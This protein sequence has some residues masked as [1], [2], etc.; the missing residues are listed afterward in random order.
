MLKTNLR[1][2]EMVRTEEQDSLESLE[3]LGSWWLPPSAVS[4]SQPQIWRFSRR[5]LVK[6]AWTQKK[7]TLRSDKQNITRSTCDIQFRTP[8]KP[9]ELSRCR[10]F[11]AILTSLISFLLSLPC[12]S[13]PKIH[14]L[15]YKRHVRADSVARLHKIARACYFLVAWLRGLCSRL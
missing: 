13:L 5:I 6:V 4:K 7:K 14:E 2:W 12:K 8:I 1:N 3:F 15:K 10:F 9:R 11:F